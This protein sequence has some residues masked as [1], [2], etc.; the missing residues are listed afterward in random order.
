MRFLI[1]PRFFIET[2][3]L[4]LHIQQQ[5]QTKVAQVKG[6]KGDVLLTFPDNLNLIEQEK[7]EWMNKVVIEVLRKQCKLLIT[8][9]LNA[10]SAAAGVKF[11]RVT[12]KDVSSRWGSCSGL[13][14]LNFNVWLLLAPKELVDYVVCHELAHLKEMN[15]SAKFWAEVDRILGGESGLAKALDKK[16]NNFARSLMTQGRYR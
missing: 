5:E 10:R 8:P 16:M 6:T 12:Y 1:T 4:Q 9:I 7:Q 11:N 3:L 15:H 2:D 14:N 13:R